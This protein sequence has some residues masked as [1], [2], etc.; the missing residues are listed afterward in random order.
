MTISHALLLELQNAAQPFLSANQTAT[1]GRRVRL[2]N[3]VGAVA[4]AAGQPPSPAFVATHTEAL[5]ALRLHLA[6]CQALGVPWTAV[7]A[8]VNGPADRADEIYRRS[9]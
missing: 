7:V 4:R 3:A 1:N 5:S 9:A 8:L 2:R 6:R